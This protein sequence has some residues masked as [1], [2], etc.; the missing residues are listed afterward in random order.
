LIFDFKTKI[1]KETEFPV[2]NH[3]S[4][5]TNHNSQITIHK[6]QFTNHNS[7]IIYEFL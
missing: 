3:Y 2:L 1:A 6:S 5:F 7:Q 4:Q